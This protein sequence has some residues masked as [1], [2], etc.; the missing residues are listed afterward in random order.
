MERKETAYWPRQADEKRKYFA[1][2]CVKNTH[3][4]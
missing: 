1:A 4:A 2:A 3:S